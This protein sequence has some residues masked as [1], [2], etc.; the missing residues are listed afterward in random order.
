MGRQQ[1]AA[2]TQKTLHLWAQEF[3]PRAHLKRWLQKLQQFSQLN[4]AMQV[5]GTPRGDA[6]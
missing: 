5:I 2:I 1:R 6:S 3:T 4:N